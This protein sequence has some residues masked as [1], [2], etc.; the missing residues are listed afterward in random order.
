MVDRESRTAVV[1]EI[2]ALART[3]VL[4]V[5]EIQRGLGAKTG[6]V[7]WGDIVKRVRHSPKLDAA[8]R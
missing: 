3:T 5:R 6:A 1:A 2:E 4:S 7:L 8:G